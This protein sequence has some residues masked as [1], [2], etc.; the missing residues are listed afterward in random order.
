MDSGQ[1]IFLSF[2]WLPCG[3]IAFLLYRFVGRRALE[4]GS[5]FGSR[6][7]V[8]YTF[9]A[10]SLLGQVLFQEQPNSNNFEYSTLFM[11]IGF[12]VLYALQKLGRVCQWNPRYV[13][14]SDS[15]EIVHLLNPQSME[16]QQYLRVD[17]PDDPAVPHDRMTLEDEKAE[18]RQR[19]QVCV[20]TLVVLVVL[21]VLEGVY[22]V[23]RGPQEWVYLAFFA[24]DKLVEMA[25]VCVACLH[26][27][28]FTPWTIAWVFVVMGSALPAL[29]GMVPDA[30]EIIVVHPATQLF[31]GLAAGVLF[32]VALYY[33]RI[34][35]KNTDVRET[36][37]RLFIFG[38]SGAL[39]WAV[40]TVI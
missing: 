2:L 1:I 28:W 11:F 31:Y 7:E 37:L 27:L 23:F 12:F 18:L 21:S 32:W 5:T 38:A 17:N 39:S 35:R 19:R 14:P 29:L 33:V 34:D 8:L 40:G 4:A 13:A 26:A 10:G 3:I 30:A 36:V 15:I 20:L 22:F 25:V 6:M 9:M 24:V 16:L